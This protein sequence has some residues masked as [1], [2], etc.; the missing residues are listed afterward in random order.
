MRFLVD[1]LRLPIEENLNKFRFD[2]WPP[3]LS[4]DIAGPKE[5]TEGADW[6]ET[7][8]ERE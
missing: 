4:T 3:S 8:E 7:G 2:F 1:L 5:R 6:L